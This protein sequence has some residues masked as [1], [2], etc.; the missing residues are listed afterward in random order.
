[1]DIF[2]LWLFA[3]ANAINSVITGFNVAFI[4]ALILAVI[5]YIIRCVVISENT[6]SDE[7]DEAYKSARQALREQVKTFGIFLA[8]GSLFFV[9]I[10][11]RTGLAIIVGGKL[12]IEGVTS[13]TVT[14]TSSKIF[15]LVDHELD[16][17]LEERQRERMKEVE[18]AEQE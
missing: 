6:P 17:R 3:Q 7:E 4:L 13:E 8:I 2:I 15:E 14:G 18:D 16:V 10:P 5:G 1:M 9:V 12:A 11:D